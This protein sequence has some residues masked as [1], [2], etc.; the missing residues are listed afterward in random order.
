MPAHLYF[1]ITM[2]DGQHM[3]ASLCIAPLC[4]DLRCSIVYVQSVI[5]VKHCKGVPT[6]QLLHKH[7]A[8]MRLLKQT[9]LYS[10]SFRGAQNLDVLLANTC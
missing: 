1:L 5:S 10:V 2:Y 8:K 6:V 9:M 3:I 7:A 4:I